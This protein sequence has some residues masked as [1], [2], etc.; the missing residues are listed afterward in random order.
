MRKLVNA[1]NIDAPSPD[2]PKG[3]VRDKSGST[4]GTIYN[5]TLVGD[6]Y[7][8][9]QKLI[10]DAEI[11]ENDLP[12]NVSNGY[13]LLDALRNQIHKD[14]TV[15]INSDYTI[16]DGDVVILVDHASN[17]VIVTLPDPSLTKN[18][19]RKIILSA[20]PYGGSSYSMKLTGSVDGT[21]ITA[22]AQFGDVVHLVSD[23][24]T[25]RILNLPYNGI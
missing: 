2:Y 12:D 25:W 10:I 22:S 3:R 18:L 17:D 14:K 16:D 1:T 21:S 13:Q 15:S 8:L 19:H 4:P 23:G 6:M 9:F 7:Q 24:T 20:K 11:T 5:E